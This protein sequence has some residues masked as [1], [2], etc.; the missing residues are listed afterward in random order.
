MAAM[1]PR[2]SGTTAPLTVPGSEMSA[3]AET[4]AHRGCAVADVGIKKKAYRR[5]C[6]DQIGMCIQDTFAPL[7]QTCSS[8]AAAGADTNRKTNDILTQVLLM[9][10]S[11]TRHT[12]VAPHILTRIRKLSLESARRHMCLS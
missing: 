1:T 11:Y 6:E 8:L 2:S 7:L 10:Q 4:A 3:M 5:R 12:A 9:L